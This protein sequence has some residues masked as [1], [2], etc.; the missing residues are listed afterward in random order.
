MNRMDDIKLQRAIQSAEKFIRTAK[1]SKR[2]LDEE[3]MWQ[4][5]P[6]MQR[7]KNVRAVFLASIELKSKIQSLINSMGRQ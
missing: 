6:P 5:K 1:A 4:H 2:A 3:G 7:N